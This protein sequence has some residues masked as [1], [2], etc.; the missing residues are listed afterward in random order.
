MV[1][2]NYRLILT[3]YL[4]CMAKNMIEISYSQSK[5]IYMRGLFFALLFLF[6]IPK[7][8]SQARPRELGVPLAFYPPGFTMLL[9]M[10][11]ESESVT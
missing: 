7:S 11:R 5:L 6:M 1:G 9:P 8:F 10:C 4:I 2:I 3:I